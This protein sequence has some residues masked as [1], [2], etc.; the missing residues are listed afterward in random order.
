MATRSDQLHSHQ[1]T[2]QRVV[3]A[4]AMRDPDPASSPLRRIGGALLRQRAGGGARPGR[5]R[6]LRRAAPGR[7]DRVAGRAT[8]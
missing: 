3:G 4:L 1:F 7:R 6:R 5:G 2:L 8:R